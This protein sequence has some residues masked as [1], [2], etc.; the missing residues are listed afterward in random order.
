MKVRGRR[1][2]KACDNR[3]SYYDTGSVACPACGSLQSVGVDDRTLHTASPAPLDLTPHRSAL[4]GSS[5]GDVVAALKSDLRE[6]ARKRGFVREGELLVLDDAYLAAH[7][8]L[9]AADVYARTREPTD[10]ERYYVGELLGGADEGERPD[11]VDVPPSMRQARGL[12]YADAVDRYRNDVS[13]WLDEHPDG[14]G[15]RVLGVVGERVKRVRSLQGDVPPE[16]AESL[17]TATRELT[18][19]LTEG[20]ESALVRAE[21]RLTDLS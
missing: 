19:Y 7:E 8:L 20:D 16:T 6:Y 17:V 10:D 1:E 21:D 14:E 11:A 2:C 3:W 5:L 13:A 15:R 4:E 9:Q 18:A 12:G